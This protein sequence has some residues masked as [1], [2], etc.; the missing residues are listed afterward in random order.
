MFGE[1]RITTGF[2]QLFCI[3][4]YTMAYMVAIDDYFYIA[5]MRQYVTSGIT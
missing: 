5:I 3:N 1:S 2:I 4:I